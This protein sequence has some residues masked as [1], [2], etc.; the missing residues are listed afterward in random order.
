LAGLTLE[1]GVPFL[2]SIPSRCAS[3][4]FLLALASASLP[5]VS[6]S[7]S[8]RRPVVY[9]SNNV[10]LLAP[11]PLLALTAKKEMK[12]RARKTKILFFGYFNTSS[13]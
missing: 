1:L 7:A 3:P 8:L 13:S 6:A 4:P 5:L 11:N 12:M 10:L 9:A 2:P